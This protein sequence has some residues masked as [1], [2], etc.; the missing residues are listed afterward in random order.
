MD[1]RLVSPV[2][3]TFTLVMRALLPRV[4]MILNLVK[5]CQRD[6][7]VRNSERRRLPT[8]EDDPETPDEWILDRERGSLARFL[9]R[10]DC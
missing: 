6:K 10:L 4:A 1:E 9:R 7:V 3:H 8:E 2:E 5:D